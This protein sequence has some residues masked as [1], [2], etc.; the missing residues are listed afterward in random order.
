MQNHGLI[1]ADAAEGCQVV[2]D[3]TRAAGTPSHVSTRIDGRCP[4]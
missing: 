1:I 4:A 2:G 3:F